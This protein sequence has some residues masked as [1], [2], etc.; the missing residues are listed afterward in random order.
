MVE[1]FSTLLLITHAPEAEEKILYTDDS[2]ERKDP[3]K[4]RFHDL[5]LRTG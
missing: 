2:K 5:H 1:T 3:K 4:Y